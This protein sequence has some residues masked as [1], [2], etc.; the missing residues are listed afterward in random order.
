LQ[1]WTSTQ[2]SGLV[3]VRGGHARMSAAD[4]RAAVADPLMKNSEAAAG[5]EP[6]PK[7]V[8]AETIGFR[9]VR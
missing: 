2:N 5:A 7:L 3:V 1:E 9:C 8:A 4:R 6:A